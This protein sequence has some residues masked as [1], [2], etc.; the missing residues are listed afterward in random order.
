MVG[1][2]VT[3]YFDSKIGSTSRDDYLRVLGEIGADVDVF[4]LKGVGHFA[5]WEAP[6][7][8]AAALKPFLQAAANA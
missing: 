7:Q 8:V 5:P 1:G 4:P 6:E 3:Q 2:R